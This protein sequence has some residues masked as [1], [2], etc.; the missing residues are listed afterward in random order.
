MF[1]LITGPVRSGKSRF[2]E[3]RAV[4]SR[5]PV[6][7]LATASRIE[8]DT[9]WGARLAHHLERRPAGWRTIE[10]AGMEATAIEQLVREGEAGTTMILDSLGTWLADQMHRIQGDD[11]EAAMTHLD[12][13]ADLLADACI[14]S[15]ARLIV[16]GEEVGWGIV[17]DNA[18][19]RMFRDVLGRLQQ[20]LARAARQAY[21]VVAGYAVDLKATGL[22]VN[23]PRRRQPKIG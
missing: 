4:R 1:I 20:R 2:A 5:G 6:T 22:P 23:P 15:K 8:G 7:Y 18:Q 16:V 17:P 14:A 11:A 13:R 21:L 9:E 10:T 19:A 12:L 3:I